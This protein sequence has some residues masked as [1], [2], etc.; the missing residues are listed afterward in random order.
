MRSRRD[1]GP[2]LGDMDTLVSFLP[3]TYHFVRNGSLLLAL[4]QEEMEGVTPMPLK[5][6][7][8]IIPK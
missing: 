6:S 5:D 2:S 1:F 4:L 8:L 3:V 7:M